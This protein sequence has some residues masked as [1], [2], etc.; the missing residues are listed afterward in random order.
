V[1]MIDLVVIHRPSPS[2]LLLLILAIIIS[3]KPSDQIVGYKAT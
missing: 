3:K 2:P 1:M